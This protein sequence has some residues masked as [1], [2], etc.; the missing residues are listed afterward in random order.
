M[1]LMRDPAD[2]PAAEMRLCVVEFLFLQ[3]KESNFC[4][5]AGPWVT[6]DLALDKTVVPCAVH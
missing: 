3:V 6:C 1:F 2:T 5:R 4:N